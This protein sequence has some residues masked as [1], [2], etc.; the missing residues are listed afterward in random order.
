MP[1]GSA[2]ELAIR[3]RTSVGN[4]NQTL[5]EV[6]FLIISRIIAANSTHNSF[7]LKFKMPNWMTETTTNAK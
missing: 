2:G 5:V 3:V 6:G 1:F 7:N 4:G